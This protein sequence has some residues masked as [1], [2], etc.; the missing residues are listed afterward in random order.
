[1]RQR[2]NNGNA[3]QFKWYGARGISVC[4]RWESFENF[5]QDMGERPRGMTLDRKDP[6]GNYCPENCRWATSKEQA[7]TNR[8][9][10]KPGLV[11]WNK[12]GVAK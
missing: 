5:L 1:M 12:K 3:T 11:P 10:F 4:E 7:V 6:D 8:G 9:I 2:C